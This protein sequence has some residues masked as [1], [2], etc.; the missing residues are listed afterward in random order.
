MH[1][2]RGYWD[3]RYHF[4]E[5][6]KAPPNPFCVRALAWS[7]ELWTRIER[8]LHILDLGA[9]DG[10]DSRA[11]AATGADVVALDVSAEG[12]ARLEGIPRVSRVVADLRL[13][14]PFQAATFDAVYSHFVLSCDFQI[15]EVEQILLELC[16]IL[17][18]GGEIWLAVRSTDDPTYRRGP[19]V[20]P[21][22]RRFGESGLHFFSLRSLRR[23]LE[24]VGILEL[25]SRHLD[26]DGEA[27]GVIEARAVKT[28]VHP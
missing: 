10:R 4:L 19:Q 27:Y 25:N 26:I 17:R 11:F 21:G 6:R 16:R 2:P 14:L 15:L 12:L 3:A 18:P 13:P 20:G 5:R 23:M 22:H 9:G 7:Q 24:P 28:L 1:D 8:D